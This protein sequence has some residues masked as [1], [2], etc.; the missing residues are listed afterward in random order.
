MALSRVFVKLVDPELVD[1]FP[2]F[3]CHNS[4]PLVPIQ[5]QTNWHHT[6]HF[7]IISSQLVSSKMA[8]DVKHEFW[9]FIF[10]VE[11]LIHWL[12]RTSMNRSQ[13]WDP[14][15]YIYCK[16]HSTECNNV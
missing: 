3:Y 6:L 12:S 5:S 8:G 4:L 9:N 15:P 10:V 16:L 11:G 7:N 13:I 2:V 14:S 1:K